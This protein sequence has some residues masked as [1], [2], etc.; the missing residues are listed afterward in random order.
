MRGAT[1]V[2][3]R[4]GLSNGGRAITS[5]WPKGDKSREMLAEPRGE[6]VV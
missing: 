3:Q 5:P 2:V 4:S 6:R 1:E